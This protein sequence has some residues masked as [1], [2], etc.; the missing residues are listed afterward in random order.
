MVLLNK[1]RFPDDRSIPQLISSGQLM[2]R[3]GAIETRYTFVLHG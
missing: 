2:F 3:D 1:I